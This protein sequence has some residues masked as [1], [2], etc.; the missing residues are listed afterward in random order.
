MP[1]RWRQRSPR[2]WAP[3][4]TTAA[5]FPPSPRRRMQTI[6]HDIVRP[7]V[8]LV[9]RYKALLGN[10][11]V[12]ALV[13]DAQERLG[14]LRAGYLPVDRSHKIA[15]PAVTI[16]LDV[17]G[18]VDCMPVLAHVEAGDVVVIA[19]HGTLDTAMWGALTTMICRE[20]G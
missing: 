3:A 12:T 16:G 14:A 2:G 9:D 11:G 7:P 4:T 18:L 5:A 13:T 8:A 20:I 1:R 15:G 6:Y 10:Y 19:A 17:D